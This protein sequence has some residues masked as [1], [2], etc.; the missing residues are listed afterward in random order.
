MHTLEVNLKSWSILSN[1]LVEVKYKTKQ[2]S[3]KIKYKVFQYNYISTEQ[4]NQ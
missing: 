3:N 2:N 4:K 1:W